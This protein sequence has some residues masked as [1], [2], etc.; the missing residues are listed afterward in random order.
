LCIIYII[1][2]TDTLYWF[3]LQVTATIVQN[4]F[5]LIDS[6]ELFIMNELCAFVVVH[7]NQKMISVFEGRAVT[8]QKRK[9]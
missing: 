1:I 7:E 8:K 4:G 6:I 3:D 9:L 5:Q 2:C